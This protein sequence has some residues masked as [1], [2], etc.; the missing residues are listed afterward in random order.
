M[1]EILFRGKR[2]DNGAWETGSLVVKRMNTSEARYYIADKMT[3]YLT[4]VIPETVG[5]YTGLKD[6][7]GTKLFEGIL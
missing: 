1:R 5:E 7:N 3:G 2:I 6:K 4:P